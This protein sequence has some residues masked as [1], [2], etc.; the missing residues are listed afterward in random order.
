MT[1]SLA[2]K[3]S[4]TDLVKMALVLKPHLRVKTAPPQKRKKDS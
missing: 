4:W 2:A 1:E 3:L